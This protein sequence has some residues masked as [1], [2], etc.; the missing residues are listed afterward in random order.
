MV[1]VLALRRKAYLRLTFAQED[2]TA[3]FVSEAGRRRSLPGRNFPR[4]LLRFPV[5]A[6]N[7]FAVQMQRRR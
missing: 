6:G 2:M 4:P 3:G 5:I 7:L 1:L